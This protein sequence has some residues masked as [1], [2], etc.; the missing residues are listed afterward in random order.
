MPRDFNAE[1]PILSAL[2]ASNYDQVGNVG[3]LNI[4]ME[5][6]LKKF[7][8][9]WKTVDPTKLTQYMN[10]SVVKEVMKVEERKAIR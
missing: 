5:D 4:T 1:L 8:K 10:F 6:A 7:T 3:R 2:G 9:D